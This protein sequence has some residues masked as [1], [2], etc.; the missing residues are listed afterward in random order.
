MVKNNRKVKL[1]QGHQLE[2]KSARLDISTN[3][4][5]RMQ[6]LTNQR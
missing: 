3:E 2:K 4:I 6:K 5:I 1:Q